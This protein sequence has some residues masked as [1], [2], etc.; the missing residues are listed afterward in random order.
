MHSSCCR[1]QQRQRHC[2]SASYR[3]ARTP[4]FEAPRGQERLGDDVVGL[5]RAEPPR[6]VAV[7]DVMVALDEDC[8]RA[9]LR[10]AGGKELSVRGLAH[11]SCSPVRLRRLRQASTCRTVRHPAWATSGAGYRLA[12]PFT[13][14][15]SR[16]LFWMV[17][18]GEAVHYLSSAGDAA[19]AASYAPKAP[20]AHAVPGS[21]EEFLV[22]RYRLF[23]ERNR[24]LI[25]VQVAHEPWPLQPADASIRLNRMSPPGIEFR[26]E[27]LLH[28]SRSVS[29][30]I[31][32]PSPVRTAAAGSARRRPASARDHRP[33]LQRGGGDGSSGMSPGLSLRHRRP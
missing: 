4:S 24:R 12:D 31:S 1:C 22:E 15:E 23:A 25:T 27:P 32:A 9:R 7:Q 28:F 26:G 14:D 8:E 2:S 16:I 29:A 6:R 19:F 21:L 17:G 13:D 20:P 11:T 18:D 3:P 33:L 30:L 10:V 5:Y